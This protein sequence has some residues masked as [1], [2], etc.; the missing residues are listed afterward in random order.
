MGRWVAVLLLAIALPL[1]LNLGW[2]PP[3]LKALLPLGVAIMEETSIPEPVL[4]LFL[5][6]GLQLGFHGLVADLEGRHAADVNAM[7]AFVEELR[8]MPVALFT[9]DANEQ[10]YEVETAFFDIALGERRKYSA[11]LW[12][13]SATVA[14]AGGPLL[15]AAE[16]RM[17]DAYV[18]RASLG[19]N[20][21]ILDLGCGWGSVTLYLAARF[22]SSKIIGVSN[23]RTQRAFILE[24]ARARGLSNVDVRTLNV[25][26]PE[27]K[28]FLAG[29]A[30]TLD[31]VISADV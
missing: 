17:L 5:R 15:E 13:A 20:M 25:A 10:H 6:P 2:L 18:D 21:T 27:F 11:G 12:E 19:N 9:A 29:L 1:A 16:D 28:E 30:G 31:R 4:D 14:E 8:Q 7:P 24:Q 23:S 3:L 26:R 22:P